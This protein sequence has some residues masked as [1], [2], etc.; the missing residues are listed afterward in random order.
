MT[1][2]LSR[3]LLW[4]FMA[5][6]FATGVGGLRGAV[7]REIY[8]QTRQLASL[9]FDVTPAATLAPATTL[10]PG[11]AL[12]ALPFYAAGRALGA[13]RVDQPEKTVSLCAQTTKL[14]APVAMATALFF[15]ALAA[16]SF[17]VR[18]SI[19][20]LGAVLAAVASPLTIYGS[21]LAPPAFG[22][23][24][25]ALVIYPTL[26]FR[27]KD[28]RRRLRLMLGLGL[29]LMLLLDDAFLLIL[30]FWLVWSVAAGRKLFGRLGPMWPTFA[31]FGALAA[32]GLAVNSTTFGGALH[33]PGGKGPVAHVLAA[34]VAPASLGH[35]WVGLKL[36]LVGA[37]PLGASLVAARGWPAEVAGRLFLGLVWWCPLLLAGAL[38]TFAMM[39][40]VT[41]RRP[42][43]LIAPALWVAVALLAVSQTAPG[44]RVA[45]AAAT[46][47][48]WGPYL[49]GLAFFIEYHLWEMPGLLFKNA[50]RL[51]FVAALV[52]SWGNG[53][54]GLTELNVGPPATVTSHTVALPPQQVPLG[55]GLPGTPGALLPASKDDPFFLNTNRAADWL[56]RRP[57]EFVAAF[58]PGLNNLSFFLPWLML[59][60][61]LTW[62][63]SWVLASSAGQRRVMSWRPPSL[64]PS[65]APPEDE[66]LPDD[67]EEEDD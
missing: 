47:A 15:L 22:L 6:W 7:E 66:P 17:G 64:P 39:R 32:F 38:G 5:V 10:R 11:P 13:M 41:A 63:G 37:A 51:V 27:Q 3:Y 23:L 61:V 26:R 19:A 42:I 40:D 48:Y 2:P 34:Y 20:A 49:I 59:A 28:Q 14:A 65:L 4:L 24:A 33:S 30:P 55:L 1:K 43:H 54:M 29:G 16:M 44:E 58:R 52:A 67:D 62:L 8:G 57:R 50:L 45:D 21:Q 18:P 56:M 25:T 53:W 46:I 9:S 36:W 35:F 31:V 12:L 60:S